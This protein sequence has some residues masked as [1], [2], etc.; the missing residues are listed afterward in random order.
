MIVVKQDLIDTIPKCCINCQF[1]ESEDFGEWWYCKLVSILHL[2]KY[3]LESKCCNCDVEER[4]EECP[5]VVII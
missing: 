3:C 2:R 5:L 4:S 1:S